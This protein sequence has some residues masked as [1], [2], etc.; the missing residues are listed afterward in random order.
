MGIGRPR[1]WERALYYS[2]ER[3]LASALDELNGV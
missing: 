1:F 3:E 2:M